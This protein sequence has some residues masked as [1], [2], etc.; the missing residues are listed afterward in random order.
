MTNGEL[1]LHQGGVCGCVCVYCGEGVGVEGEG[2][3]G[4]GFRGD[5]ALN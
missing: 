3:R 4:R 5:E 2:L 1:R